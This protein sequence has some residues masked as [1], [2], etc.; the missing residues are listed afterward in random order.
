MLNISFNVYRGGAGEHINNMNLSAMIPY[1]DWINVL[2]YD[3]HGSWEAQTNHQAALYGNDKELQHDMIAK[4][5]CDAVT[6]AYIDAGVPSDKIVIGIPLFGRGWQGIKNNTLNGYLQPTS[7]LIPNGTW[8]TGVFEY[9]HLKK[10]F[11]PTYTCYFDHQSKASFLYNSST[12]IW[13]SYEDLESLNWK[14][15]YIKDRR[16]RGV[17]FWEL[18]SD[19]QLKLIGVA[20]DAFNNSTK[21]SSMIKKSGQK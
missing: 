15:K 9:D 1:I 14:I 21:S 4:L 3:F 6:Q 13:I 16:L 10:D 17:Y 2:T 11:I 7:S 8:E 19:R 20:F 12:S 5:N 18:S